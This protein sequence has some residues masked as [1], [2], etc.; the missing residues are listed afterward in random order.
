MQPEGRSNW[1]I[2]RET[3]ERFFAFYFASLLYLFKLCYNF[4]RVII[5]LI[6][7]TILW[8]I[9]T[10][11]KMVLLFFAMILLVIGPRIGL[12][13][14]VYQSTWRLLLRTG[15]V[16]PSSISRI[17]RRNRQQQ[18]DDP[19]AP[20]AEPE[21]P[22][23]LAGELIL[24]GYERMDVMLAA[25]VVTDTV[26]DVV[27]ELF[28][29]AVDALGV[30]DYFRSVCR[31][32]ERLKHHRRPSHAHTDS[33]EEVEE[34]YSEA[35]GGWIRRGSRHSGGRRSVASEDEEEENI[36]QSGAM[37]A[38]VLHKGEETTEWALEAT[39]QW[40]AQR[41]VARAERRREKTLRAAEQVVVGAERAR[42]REQA[43]LLSLEGQAAFCCRRVEQAE[44]DVEYWTRE[45]REAEAKLDQASA[46]MLLCYAPG[47]YCCMLE[48]YVLLYA[49]R[50]RTYCTE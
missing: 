35:R 9:T 33:D 26:Q 20:P 46:G 40:W 21:T 49:P 32:K 38:M 44:K 11:L 42:D 50:I 31:Y 25:S 22:A 41:K 28:W 19:S 43:N 47:L 24:V 17:S 2:L 23:E 7:N 37:L 39:Q 3:T 15:A 5:P 8:A 18:E 14:A 6:V 29:T 16:T 4:L 36:D 34:V 10:A 27:K 48:R 45:T 12:P 30:G 1:V 13:N